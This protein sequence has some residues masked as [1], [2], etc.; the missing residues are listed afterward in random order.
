MREAFSRC[1]YS[2]EPMNPE[3]MKYGTCRILYG[4][5]S[6]GQKELERIEPDLKVVLLCVQ[7]MEKNENCAEVMMWRDFRNA[8]IESN[9]IEMQCRK[10]PIIAQ[11]IMKKSER[12][13]LF[14]KLYFTLVM[15]VVLAIDAA[16]YELAC[17]IYADRISDLEKQY[18][19][20][21]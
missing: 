18:L 17:S 5:D 9:V 3:Y 20:H 12:E 6:K 13:H 14:R 11:E 10:M 1:K 21:S 8:Y 7:S 19:P 2:F 16:Q 15:P 4:T